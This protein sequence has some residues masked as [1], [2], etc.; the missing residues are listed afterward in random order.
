VSVDVLDFQFLQSFLRQRCAIV[1]GD[2]KHYLVEA[3]LSPIARDLGLDTAGEV[4]RTLRARKDVGLEDRVVEA[5]TTNETS[6]FR[7]L[8]PFEAIRAEVIPEILDRNRPARHLAVWSAAA[9]TGQEL[10]SLALMLD[11]HF[12]ELAGW[13]VELVGTDLNSAVLEKARAGRFS[14]LEINRGLPA[15][16]IAR[17]FTREGAHFVVS[18]EIRS[19]VRFEKMNL[20]GPWVGLPKFDLVL[21]RNV[22]IYFDAEDKRRILEKAL[23]QLNPGG[24]LLLGAA[25]SP[26]GLL[27]GV[28]SV[29][30][31]GTTFYR[32]E[33]A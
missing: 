23:A 31:L 17:Y 9:S 15:A 4:V 18:P 20:A 26:Y 25:E 3:R 29:S 11:Q 2:D 33:V 19:R 13:R 10:Y 16:L 27:R 22:L 7:D 8:Q 28:T 14:G 12:P 24:Y 1:L 5:M 21:L 32:T 6:W 30:I